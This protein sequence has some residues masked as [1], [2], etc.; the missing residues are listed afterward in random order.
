VEDPKWTARYH[1]DDPAVKAFGGKIRIIMKDGR[2]IEDEMAVANAHSLGATPWK[3]PDYVRKFR[4]LTDG[5]LTD[6]EG[7]RFLDVVQRLPGVSAAELA[8]LTIALPADKLAAGATG[9]IFDWR[10]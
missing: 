2:V 3:R 9:G 8:G 1:A 5:I 4:T 7:E 10:T 6:A